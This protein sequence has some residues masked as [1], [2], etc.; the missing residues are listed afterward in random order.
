MMYLPSRLP[1]FQSTPPARGATLRPAAAPAPASYFN[2]RPP[3]GG[4]LLG[5]GLGVVLRQISIHAP[6]EGGDCSAAALAL[7]CVRFQSTPPA[8]GAT[9]CFAIV[10]RLIK[11]FNPRPPRGGRLC[12]VPVFAAGATHFNPRPPRGG[13]P[14]RGNQF[15]HAGLISIHAPRE[16]GDQGGH[17]GRSINVQISI[18]APREG[19][20]AA[21]RRQKE[22]VYI[23]QS[24]PPARGATVTM[25]IYCHSVDISIHAPREGGDPHRGQTLRLHHHFNPRPP[26]GGRL[27]PGG[28]RHILINFNPRPPRGGR[29]LRRGP[30]YRYPSSISIHAPREGGD[31]LPKLLSSLKGDFNPR[32]PRGGRQCCCYRWVRYY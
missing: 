32:P 27:H 7:C 4:R 10:I 16:G 21:R 30:A 28:G 31:N 24:T 23:F 19:G 15:L 26:R 18:H 20:D 17:I 11:D 14:L 9:F 6:R 8:R 29:P 25:E 5:C 12:V 1:V 2:P 13:R 3:R 22:R